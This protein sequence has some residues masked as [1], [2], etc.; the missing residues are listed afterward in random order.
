MNIQDVLKKCLEIP[1]NSVKYHTYSTELCLNTADGKG[2]MTFFPLFP[3]ITLAYIFVNASVWNAPD[4]Q[5]NAPNGKGMLL[6]NYC[7]EGRCELVLNNQTYVYVKEKELSFT[8]HFA[9]KQYVYPNHM[10]E[11]I[12]FF[13]DPNTILKECPYLHT[14]FALSFQK[15]ID[16]YCPNES[17]YI[18]SAPEEA[19][20]I[21]HTLWSLFDLPMPFA[22]SQM[23]LYTI[24]L[25]ST[26]SN[27]QNIPKS[28]LRAF[29][30]ET[31]VDIAKRTMQIVTADLKQ[32]YPI[33]ELADR[34]SISETSLKNYFRG[35]YGQNISVYLREQRMHTA[36]ELLASTRLPISEIAEQVGYQNQSKFAT[37]FKNTYQMSP[38]EY[39][40]FRALDAER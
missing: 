25:F 12:E 18:A 20:D 8:E 5:Q 26:L 27:L 23:K 39:R 15:L 24:L 19:T 32:H 33:R 40:R 11:G 16:L 29:F 28:Q 2:S 17:T 14:D 30:T 3:G 21:L 10:Y 36:A 13:L 31:Q 38:L 34:F 22:L 7:T 35:V 37:V 4:M 1:G 9:G 6:F